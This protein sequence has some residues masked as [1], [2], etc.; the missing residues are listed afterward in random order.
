ML[1]V[2][3]SGGSVSAVP[4]PLLLSKS[5]PETQVLLPQRDDDAIRRRRPQSRTFQCSRAV[6][7]T[8][9]PLWLTG[10]EYVVSGHYN[11]LVVG[12]CLETEVAFWAA[13]NVM[14]VRLT[15]VF[16]AFWS[17]QLIAALRAFYPETGGR[18][19]D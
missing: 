8:A 6:E 2:S 16:G 11:R 10:T 1:Q 17:D 12:S 19:E 5:L 9:G 13:P 14:D 3:T 15:P 4:S 18:V 7:V